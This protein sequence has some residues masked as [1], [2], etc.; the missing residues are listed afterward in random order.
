MIHGLM[1]A[2]PVLS[3]LDAREIRLVEGTIGATMRL[4]I[5]DRASE[6]GGFQM[7]LSRAAAAWLPQPHVNQSRLRLAAIQL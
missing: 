3:G 6:G 7:K 1:V 5:P 4:L 2:L